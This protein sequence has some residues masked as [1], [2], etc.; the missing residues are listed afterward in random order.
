MCL[1]IVHPFVMN[2][3]H[4]P[5]SLA[6]PPAGIDD[7]QLKEDSMVV[8]AELLRMEVTCQLSRLSE[9]R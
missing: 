7:G 4:F 9:F 8:N 5:L 3:F 2:S 6:V 1:F